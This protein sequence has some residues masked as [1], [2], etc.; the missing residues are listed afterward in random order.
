M[1]Q[2][3]RSQLQQLARIPLIA[4]M[5][6]VVFGSDP[7][8]ALPLS[9]AELYEKFVSRLLDKQRWPLDVRRKLHDWVRPYGRD[10]AKS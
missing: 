6:C 1:A 2:L 8:Q 4:A 3:E 5:M 9:R 7:E 10:A